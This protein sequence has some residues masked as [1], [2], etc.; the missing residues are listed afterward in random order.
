VLSDEEVARIW[1][2]CTQ[3]PTGLTEN[4]ADFMRLLLLTGLRRGEASQIHTAWISNNVLTIPGSVTKNKK[5]LTI[6]LGSLAIE[7]IRPRMTGGLLFPGRL[8]KHQ[9]FDNWGKPKAALDRASGVTGWVIHTTRH[10]F[11][12]THAKLGT[13][14]P[15]IERMLNHT[16][17]VFGGIVG[18]YQHADFFEEMVIAT[19]RYEAHISRIC[20]IP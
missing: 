7:I 19:A 12:T 2:T 4:F 1:K 9:P 17:G 20:E 5:P 15:C 11:A 6:P 16:S 3:Y 10:Y 18:V 13:S 14:I 8:M